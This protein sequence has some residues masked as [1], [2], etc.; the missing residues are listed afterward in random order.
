MIKE[1]PEIM[2]GL[3]INYSV[4]KGSDALVSKVLKG[5]GDICIVPSNVAAIAYNKEAKYKLAGTVGFGSLYVISSD[6]SVNSLEDLKG[7]DV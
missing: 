1:K 2:K 5:E 3:D 4:V 7:K 6:D